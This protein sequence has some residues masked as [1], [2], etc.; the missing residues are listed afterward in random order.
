MKLVKIDEV[1]ISDHSHLTSDDD[2]Y[3]LLNYKPHVGFEGGETNSLI[4][5]FKKSVDKKGKYE[6]QYKEADIRKIGSYILN[7]VI[8]YLDVQNS[9]LVPMP[10][11]KTKGH[12]LYDDRMLRALTIGSQNKIVDIRELVFHNVDTEPTHNSDSKRDPVALYNNLSIDE[13][14]A[15]NMKKNIVVFDDVITTGAHFAACKRKLNERFPE[16]NVMGIFIARREPEIQGS[17]DILQMLKD[18]FG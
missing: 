2:C 9:V 11:S 8:P 3:Y 13:A 6:Y 17:E 15:G 14:L 10:P 7:F 4:L 1:V 16:A 5:N 18:L 12:P